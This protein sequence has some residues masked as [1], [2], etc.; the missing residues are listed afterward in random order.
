MFLPIRWQERLGTISQIYDQ[1]ASETS[2]TKQADM[3]RQFLFRRD[4][5]QEHVIALSIIFHKGTASSLSPR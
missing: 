5:V 1:L 2:T 4:R 3:G